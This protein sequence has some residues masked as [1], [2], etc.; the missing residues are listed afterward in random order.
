[1][2]IAVYGGSFNPPHLGHAEAAKTVYNE[3]RP[4]L[5]LIIPD[6]IPPHKDMAEGSPTA[7]QRMELCSLAFRDVPGAQISDIELHREGKSYTADTVQLLRER[8]PDDELL[9]VMGTDMLLSFEEW[10]RFEY[11][12][13][14]CTLAVLARGE[15]EGDVLREH[16][17]YLTQRYG[18][19]IRIL[20][21]E[22]L[23]MQSRD[24]RERLKLRLCADLL[25][26][27]VYGCIIRN[28]YYDA[29]PELS[30]LREKAYAYLS[31]KR[32]AHVAGCESEAVL[33]AK[34][35][36]E[37]PEIAATAGILHDITKKLDFQEQL[38]LCE[39]YGIICDNAE[40]SNPKLLHART[41][42]ALARELFG[43]SDAVY[44]AIRWHTT[45]KPD[46]TMLEKIIY[47]AD[48]IEP[49]RDFP[50]VDAL[51]EK[52]YEDLNAAMALGLGM[53]LEEIRSHGTEPYKDTVEAYQWYC[54]DQ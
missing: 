23:P 1:M 20:P 51:R 2:R 10:Y 21:H 25:D 52:A 39:K 36:G 5:F 12:L 47:L 29:Q 24:I 8:Y 49:T 16:A 34:H 7:E 45:G 53:S 14:S 42:A 40:L 50:G 54:R 41:G 31:P 26:D 9:L 3:L 4:D 38:N 6:N 44:E 19:R 28:G 48:Y 18:A 27:R 11:L 22:P 43:I 13:H 17:A 33:L 30:W 46:M 15:L 37:D 32:I 35:W